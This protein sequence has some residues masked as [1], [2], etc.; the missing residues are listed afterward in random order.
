M[1][2]PSAALCC[3]VAFDPPLK[4]R[5]VAVQAAEDAQV[6]VSAPTAAAREARRL[7]HPAAPASDIA[8]GGLFLVAIAS[9]FY[10]QAGDD[11]AALTVQMDL[12]MDKREKRD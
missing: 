10:L 11:A 8:A 6:D 12:S 3:H 7:L 9:D 1:P 2:V 5:E 4:D